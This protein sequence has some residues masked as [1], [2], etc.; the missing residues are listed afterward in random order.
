MDEKEADGTVSARWKTRCRAVTDLDAV[1]WN[2]RALA[3]E[4][5][6]RCA[7]MA[8]V[9]GDGYG[10]GLLPLA[11]T[12]CACGVPWLGTAT[13]EEAEALRRDGLEQP[14]LILGPTPPERAPELARLEIS[15][16]VHSMDYALAL[17]RN[18]KSGQRLRVHL[19]ADTGMGRLGWWLT[20]DTLEPVCRE[21]LAIAALPGLYAEGV[22]SQL[23]CGRGGDAASLAYTDRQA[24]LFS[25][26]CAAL[27]AHGLRAPYRHILNSGG[28]MHRPEYAMDMVRVGHLLCESLP[29][30]EHLGLRS[31]MT[32]RAAIVSI[33]ELPAGASVG[34]GRAFPL[35]SPSRIAVVAIGHSD[36]YPG[37]L[38]GRGH[39]LLHGQSVP[40]LE[41]C[42][43]RT[44]ADVTGVPDAQVGEE[45]VIVGRDGNQELTMGDV[46]RQSGGVIDAPLSAC[47]TPR[48]PRYCCRHGQMM[49]PDEVPK[50]F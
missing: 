32:L 1:A 23:A 27:E 31:A 3:R 46:F 38:S 2:I 30:A 41:V 12:C 7:L 49:L 44:M 35:R 6:E 43:D 29:G 5:P 25:A 9:K 39:F 28:L 47:F 10:L 21:M 42:M 48:L 20:E 19:A 13:L 34:Y 26:L 15:Q 40:V 24:R 16:L 36:G 45:V 4:L 18:L 8:V 50:T 11:R 37:A 33:K 17:S 22:M 14:I